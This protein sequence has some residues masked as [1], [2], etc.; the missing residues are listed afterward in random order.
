MMEFP[1]GCWRDE[2]GKQIAE[3]SQ[4]RDAR[5]AEALATQERMDDYQRHQNSGACGHPWDG[6][7]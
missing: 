3:C 2:N 7:D 1:C 4:H 5:I 6:S